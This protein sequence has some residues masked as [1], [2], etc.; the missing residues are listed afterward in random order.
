MS[1]GRKRSATS[2]SIFTGPS[3]GTV[4]SVSLQI[5]SVHSNSANRYPNVLLNRYWWPEIQVGDVLELRSSQKDHPCI[6][7]IDSNDPT[8]LPTSVQVCSRA[9]TLS[10]SVGLRHNR[11]LFHMIYQNAL[12]FQVVWMLPFSK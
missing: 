7:I 8:N 2:S 1:S 10:A 11:F 12:D 5:T 4:D 9:L 6:F 3:L